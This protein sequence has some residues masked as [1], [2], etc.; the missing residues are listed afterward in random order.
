MSTLR[1]LWILSAAGRTV[2]ETDEGVR[3]DIPLDELA[4]DEEMIAQLSS[5]DAF[6]LGYETGFLRS[7]QIR[8]D[9]A[10]P[11]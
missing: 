11:Q 10:A 5:S 3:L 6:R 8:G 4:T 9:A 7:T 2:L 1:I